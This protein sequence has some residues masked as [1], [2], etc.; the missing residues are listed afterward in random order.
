[1]R[2]V[3][4]GVGEGDL[5]GRAALS[6]LPWAAGRGFGLVGPAFVGWVVGTRGAD[7]W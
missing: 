2:T 4:A 7:P 6:R 3:I 1:M 5:T